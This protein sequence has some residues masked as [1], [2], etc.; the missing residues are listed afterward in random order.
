MEKKRGKTQN[1][2]WLPTAIIVSKDIIKAHTDITQTIKNFPSF[3][4]SPK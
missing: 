2:L 3:L 1:V 4:F